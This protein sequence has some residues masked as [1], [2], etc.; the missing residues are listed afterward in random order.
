M[1]IALLNS[2]DLGSIRDSWLIEGQDAPSQHLWGYAELASM[3]HEVEII[4]FV[5]HRWVK[6]LGKRL[7]FLGDL[8]LQWQ[9]LTR[10]KEFDVVLCGHHLTSALLS[11]CRRFHL[12]KL[13]VVAIAYQGPRL[14]SAVWRLHTSL[15][16]TG[17]DIT[18]CLSERLL[19]DFLALGVP[20]N[21]LGL[22]S[23]G[24][25]LRHYPSAPLVTQPTSVV[26]SQFMLMPGKSFRDYETIAKAFASIKDCRLVITGFP[27]LQLDQIH[28]TN[29]NIE[30]VREFVPWRRLIDLYVNALAV[31]IPISTSAGIFN[32]AIGL[33]NVTEALACGK[34]LLVTRNSY[35]GIDIEAAGVGIWIEPNSHEAWT[36]AVR[37]LIDHP[38]ESALMG[39]RAHQLAVS[40]Y[41]INTYSLTVEKYLWQARKIDNY[42]ER[43]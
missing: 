33:T 34:P 15:F 18:L 8:D 38:A 35:L 41:N 9:I 43:A 20:A 27:D 13:P 5:K 31:V 12:L 37:W 17:N 25:E 11:L 21:R 4:P 19:Q 10:S 14:R 7:K 26:A 1:K 40:K 16:V 28:M 23:W 6:A 2:Y 3:G 29:A 30:I 36:Q 22:L 32:N 42:T 39:K 24:V